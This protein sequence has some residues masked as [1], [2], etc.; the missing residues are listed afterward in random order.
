MS[1]YIPRPGIVHG[2]Y[3]EKRNKS[4]LSLSSYS[5]NLFGIRKNKTQ[6]KISTFTE[7]VKKVKI[8]GNYFA[9]LQ[10]HDLLCIL[11]EIRF[12][13][14]TNGIIEDNI[15]QSFALI[16]ELS[17]R[18]LG[19]KHYDVQIMGAW[20]MINGMLAEL[21][22]GEGKT[23]TA[24]LVAGTSALAGTPTHILTVND[25]LATR[26]AE[27]MAPLYSA[28]GITVGIATDKQ[29]DDER[30]VAYDCD[31]T[32]CTGKQIAFDYLRDRITLKNNDSQLHLQLAQLSDELGQTKRLFLK[33][34]CFAII[35]EADS[36]LADDALN[37]L[38]IAHEKI[39]QE[40]ETTYQQVLSISRELDID[41]D[42][43]VNKKNHTVKLTKTGTIKIKEM[44]ELHGG[45]WKGEKRRK[46]LIQLGLSAIYLYEKNKH[47]LVEDNKVVIID[48]NTGR[49]MQD[50][51][52][53]YGLHQMVESKEG[54]PLTGQKNTLAKLT[55][56]SFFRRYLKLSGMSGTLMDLR[57]ELHHTYGIGIVGIPSNRESQREILPTRLFV[58]EEEKRLACVNS[59]KAV[60]E[61]GRPVLIGSRTILEADKISAL[62]SKNGLDHQVLNAKHTQYEAE[63]IA[64]AGN[65]GSI[66][67]ATNVAGRGTDI[68][69][70]EKSKEFGGLHVIVVEQND[71]RRIDYQL[72]GRCARQG[73]PGSTEML[74]SLEDTI[75]VQFYPKWFLGLLTTMS[76]ENTLFTEWLDKNAIRLPQVFIEI[77]QRKIRSALLKSDLQFQKL[78]SFTGNPD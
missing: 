44:G 52:W 70:D 68:V 60:H 36:I 14:I 27:L 21:K 53:E 26:D 46:H 19:M 77:R 1:S 71:A 78:L 25:Y 29:T 9:S 45:I 8:K 30:R 63:I 64:T 47:Y 5:G 74:L 55:F 66:I 35:D 43:L 41:L 23:L 13:L 28:L 48:Q 57:K 34:L 17:S 72:F 10:M 20:V 4:E 40:Q 51:T 56:Q 73:D 58:T 67:V 6:K 54:C 59:V 37:P 3:P 7:I 33:G 11:D 69:L 16:R 50:R 62:L 76:L 24:T 15:I 32:Y 22:T 31:V 18:T 38:V 61:Q 42:F 65:C 49:L 39:S 12:S 2:L 75:M